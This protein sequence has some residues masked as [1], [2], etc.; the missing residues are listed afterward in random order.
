MQGKGAEGESQ[1]RQEMERREGA[2]DR[3]EKPRIFQLFEGWHK[4]LTALAWSS[5]LPAQLCPPTVRREHPP[6]LGRACANARMCHCIAGNLS[7]VTHIVPVPVSVLRRVRH[8][9]NKT[10]EKGGNP[11]VGTKSRRD[12]CNEVHLKINSDQDE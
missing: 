3:E 10:D 12:A 11:Y 7:F 6:T 8:G 5:R 1:R 9:E 4:G 2:N